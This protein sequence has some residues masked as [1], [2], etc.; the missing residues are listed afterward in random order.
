MRLGYDC[1]SWHEFVAIALGASAEDM[2]L[3]NE[4]E[5]LSGLCLFLVGFFSK[6]RI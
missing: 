3:R 5:L 4:P 6:E 1:K 2:K